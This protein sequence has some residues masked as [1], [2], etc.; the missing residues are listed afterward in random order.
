[1]TWDIT[2]A[3]IP[4]VRFVT[5]DEYRKEKLTYVVLSSVDTVLTDALAVAADEHGVIAN[6]FHPDF[7]HQHVRAVL[8]AEDA[9]VSGDDEDDEDEL[10]LVYDRFTAFVL[11]EKMWE[12][13]NRGL[14]AHRG[15]G[16]AFD[17]R[18]ALPE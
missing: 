8:A 6:F 9:E 10:V 17:F 14:L 15:R 3:A 4:G 5:P 1:M 11:L 7:Y 18:L 2:T 13:V 16:D 12:L